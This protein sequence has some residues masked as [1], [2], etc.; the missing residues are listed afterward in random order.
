MSNLSRNNQV[1][2]LCLVVLVGMFSLA[3][4]SAPLYRMFCQ[5]TGFD[6]TP[7]RAQFASTTMTDQVIEVRF[8][9]NTGQNLP[10][11]FRPKQTSM[12]LKLGENADTSYFAKNMSTE[13]VVGTSTF[14]VTPL[15]AAPY[16]NKTECFC[17]QRQPLK[18]GE[19]ADLG[20]AFFIDPAIALNPETKDIKAITFS[21]TF[22]PAKGEAQ[23]V[24]ALKTP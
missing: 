6:G 15:R 19:T 3:Y 16:V 18:A 21:Y 9:A 13:E 22:F 8:D 14:N 17:F 1:L 11:Q 20:I 7:M 2:G 10:W 24:A 5:L 4:A 23:N 12:K